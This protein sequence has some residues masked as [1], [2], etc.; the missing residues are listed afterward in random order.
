MDM[1]PRMGRAS[2]LI[3][4]GIESYPF[5]DED[6]RRRVLETGTAD[7]E[8]VRL[9][10]QPAWASFGVHERG[11]MLLLLAQAHAELGTIER[12]RMFAESCVQE[13]PGSRYAAQAAGIL[14][15][16][17]QG[18]VR[19]GD[20]PAADQPAPMESLFAAVFRVMIDHDL[21]EP[22][23]VEARF[24]A[25][26]SSLAD[27]KGSPDQAL[28]EFET[29]AKT[30]GGEAWSWFGAAAIIRSGRLFESG[31]WQ[32]AIPIW[33][34]GK[35]RLEQGVSDSDG[36]IGAHFARGWIY[37]MVAQ[38]EQ[39]PA[40][41]KHMRDAAAKDLALVA[42]GL[43]EPGLADARASVLA[44]LASVEAQ[45]GNTESAKEH[46]GRAKR[47]V[48]SDHMRTLIAGVLG[49]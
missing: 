41:G 16:I 11:N 49:G 8:L 27:A 7:M 33:E 40:A 17:E 47:A 37:A 6:E 13:V 3:S 10:T 4:V 20:A 44:G 32:P 39:D 43:V 30:H 45:R 5:G 38:Y 18:D 14:E 25:F 46:A 26:E 19:R 2:L 36:A 9:L 31:K 21:V 1:G 34:N 12:A 29:F 23:G 35:A 28:S 22:K 15:R 42:D 48:E 24:A